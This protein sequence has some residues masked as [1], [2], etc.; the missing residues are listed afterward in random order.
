MRGSEHPPTSAGSWT[1]YALTCHPS[2]RMGTIA[3][4]C[5]AEPW[6]AS[7]S[8]REQL[9]GKQGVLH[10]APCL[11]PPYI[12]LFKE[13]FRLCANLRFAAAG[14]VTDA[15]DVG[16]RTWFTS[17]RTGR[18]GGTSTASIAMA[19]ISNIGF[20]FD[21]CS[22]AQVLTFSDSGPQ[23][24]KVQLSMVLMMAARL[25]Q[26]ST[27][28]AYR[29]KNMHDALSY[30]RMASYHWWTHSSPWPPSTAC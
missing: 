20:K 21:I 28:V 12:P 11:I 9:Q 19:L 8:R 24:L 23:R 25:W 10:N 4:N 18:L 1:C 27:E 2:L 13:A 22:A 29:L 7:T 17:A 30:E 14:T 26:S 15:T 3:T 6:V 5:S 16:K